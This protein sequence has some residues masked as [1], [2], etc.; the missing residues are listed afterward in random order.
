M[1]DPAIVLYTVSSGNWMQLKEYRDDFPMDSVLK[2]KPCRRRVK[3]TEKRG[4]L[5]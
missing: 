5:S 3:M 4:N 1:P 2:A